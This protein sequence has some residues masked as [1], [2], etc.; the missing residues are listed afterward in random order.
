M[1]AIEEAAKRA[2]VL[3]VVAPAVSLYWLPYNGLPVADFADALWLSW[4][5]VAAAMVTGYAIRRLFEAMA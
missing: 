4:P 2:V 1:S 5:F 3:F